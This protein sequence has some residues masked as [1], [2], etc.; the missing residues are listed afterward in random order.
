MRRGEQGLVM[1]RVL[2][3]T[4]GK[5]ANATVVKSSG[6][7]RLDESALKAVRA[8]RFKPHTVNGVPRQA[9]ADIPI[10]FVL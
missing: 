8:A 2:I 6:H 7:P 9:L 3:S 1:V 10:N 4:S 5:V